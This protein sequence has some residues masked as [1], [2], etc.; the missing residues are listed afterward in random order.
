ML[1]TKLG[2]GI[3]HEVDLAV[4][5]DAVHLAPG[6][7]DPGVVEADDDDHV[8]ALGGHL[9]Q[10]LE[11]GRDV[12]GLAAGGEGA[13]DGDEDDLVGRRLLGIGV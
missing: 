8:D 3:A 5:F 7:H 11:H 10:I 9:V 12:E 6:G 2:L 4:A 1:L 13:G